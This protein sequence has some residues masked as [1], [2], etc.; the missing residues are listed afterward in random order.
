MDTAFKAL[1]DPT[2]RALL[3]A[4]FARDGQ[5]L[6]SLAAPHDMTRIAVAKHLR[7]LEEAGLV[8]SRRR[9]REKLHFLNPVPIRLIH[10]RWVSKYT[11][12]WAAGLIGLKDELEHPME[13][14]FE[15]YIRTTPERLWEAI[16]DPAIREKYHFGVRAES[17]WTPGSSYALVHPGADGALAEG[18]NLEVD[19]PRRLV[20]SMNV[21][22]SDEAKARAHLARDVG[23]RAGRRLVPADGH[24]RPAQRIGSRGDLRRLADDPLRPEDVAGDRRD[25]HHPRLADVRRSMTMTTITDV[26]TIGITVADQ[27]D[28]LAFY[29]DRLGFEKRLDAPISPTMR[30][31]EVAP[32]GAKASIALN[33]REDATDEPADTGIRFTVPDAEAE[34]AAMRERGVDVGE[35]LRWDGVPPMYTFDDPDGNRFY[36]VE[37]MQ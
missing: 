37:E 4:L 19:P 14:V 24:P 21:L 27:D 12:A 28:A 13:K 31:I 16:T 8:V 32:V 11:E 1:G 25:P 9:G 26:R 3:D 30:W 5:T 6:V 23:D 10:D 22:W 7:L 20:Q 35:L 29:V 36:V 15:I 33:A 34:H 17:E 2:R 18:E